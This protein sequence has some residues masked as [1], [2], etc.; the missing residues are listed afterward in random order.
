[1][2]METETSDNED[3]L[4]REFMRV[5][6]DGE[7]ADPLH[8]GLAEVASIPRTPSPEI[9]PF[10]VVKACHVAL[11]YNDQP[12]P[13]SGFATCFA[14]ADSMCRATAGPRNQKTTLEDFI[15]YANNPTFGSMKNMRS[16]DFLGDINIIAGS[17]TRGALATQLVEIETQDGRMR[18]FLWTLQQQRRPPLQGCWLVRECLATERAYYQTL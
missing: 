3:S 15:R 5:L 4:A 1:M 10:D 13:N 14:F 12:L 6:K 16:Y 17:P 2:S 11:K 8:V 7:A 9:H 18:K